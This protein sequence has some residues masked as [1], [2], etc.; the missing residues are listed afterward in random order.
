MI[1]RNYGSIRFDLGKVRIDRGVER[2]IRRERVFEI[3]AQVLFDRIVDKFARVANTDGI[4]YRIVTSKLGIS[5]VWQR[6]LTA[7]GLGDRNARHD[8]E[9]TLILDRIESR[10]LSVLDQKTRNISVVRQP[11]VKFVVKTVDVSRGV[12]SPHLAFAGRISKRFERDLDLDRPAPVLDHSLRF[13]DDIDR[14]I[15]SAALGENTILLNTER[16]KAEHIGTTLVVVGVEPH[17]D[18]VFAKYFVPLCHGRS[19]LVLFIPT[20]ECDVEMLLVVHHVGLCRFGRGGVIAGVCL[21]EIFENRRCFPYLVVEPA[22]DRRAGT[23]LWYRDRPQF[24]GRDV[25]L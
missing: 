24:F 18:V 3:D 20:F 5:R 23:D 14:K 15:G 13:H 19:D 9:R 21:V 10:D 1:C 8:L 4:K 22:V 12:K 17:S 2:N 6:P 25:D 7:S 11:L 16:I